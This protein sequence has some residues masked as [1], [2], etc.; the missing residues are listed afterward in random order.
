[1][2]CLHGFVV[3]H[4]TLHAFL[5]SLFYFSPNEVGLITNMSYLCCC[6]DKRRHG[7]HF[8]F[9]NIWCLLSATCWLSCYMQQM[10]FYHSRMEIVFCK[11]NLLD[12]QIPK[13]A[14]EGTQEKYESLAKT[15]ESARLI[16]LLQTR[17]CGQE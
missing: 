6:V 14:Q 5:L 9:Y 4:R 11:G 17:K 13:V 1:M 12:R 2:F 7:F 16:C 15:I 10:H 3:V 8:Y